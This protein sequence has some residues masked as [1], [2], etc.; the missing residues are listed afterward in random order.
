MSGLDCGWM[1]RCVCEI[2]GGIVGRWIDGS[3]C[4]GGWDCG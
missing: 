4:M 1:G 2:V 3:L